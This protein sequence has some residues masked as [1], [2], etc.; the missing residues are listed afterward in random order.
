MHKTW[1]DIFC[2][3]LKEGTLRD[4][5]LTLYKVVLNSHLHHLSTSNTMI[6]GF[7]LSVLQ[8]YARR[9]KIRETFILHLPFPVQRQPFIDFI[10][11]NPHTN[12]NVNELLTPFKDDGRQR[13]Q[14]DQS[15]I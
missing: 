11:D 12:T 3:V 14:E 15:H 2:W 13:F 4:A 8:A 10:S 6:F 5:K 9:K 1:G 7:S